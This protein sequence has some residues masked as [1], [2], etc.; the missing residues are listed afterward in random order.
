MQ[1]RADILGRQNPS[2]IIKPEFF[3]PEVRNWRRKLAGRF[4]LDAE[5]AINTCGS[6]ITRKFHMG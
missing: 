5:P 2:Y 3:F 6:S 4:Y 1:I